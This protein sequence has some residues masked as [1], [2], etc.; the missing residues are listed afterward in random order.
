[1]EICR[2]SWWDVSCE[3]LYE[4]VTRELVDRYV[5]FISPVG[6]VGMEIVAKENIVSICIDIELLDIGTFPIVLASQITTDQLACLLV[7]PLSPDPLP[8]QSEKF[9]CALIRRFSIVVK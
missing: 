5:P 9:L 6:L 3:L 8:I 2:D 1:L 4:R 7:N